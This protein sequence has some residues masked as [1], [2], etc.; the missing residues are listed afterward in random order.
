MRV[1]E[2]ETAL[3]AAQKRVED[4]ETALKTTQER[5]DAQIALLDQQQRTLQSQVQNIQERLQFCSAKGLTAQMKKSLQEKLDQFIAYLEKVG[6]TNLTTQVSVC[7]FSKDEPIQNPAFA[8]YKDVNTLYD[9]SAHN[10]YIHSDLARV[11]S[12]VLRAYTDHALTTVPDKP[13]DSSSSELIG[14][15][16]DYFSASFLDSPL[17]GEGAGSIFGMKTSYVRT[18]ATD[19]S[20]PSA[21]S[22]PFARGEV[23]G[24]VLWH[25]RGEL[26]RPVV[27]RIALQALREAGKTKSPDAAKAFAAALVQNEAMLGKATGCFNR[28]IQQRNLPH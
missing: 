17:I 26:S 21:G 1:G 12:V 20:Y 14:G 9:A 22:E 16:G 11:P 13:N 2:A 4:T 23:W 18:L 19:K 3:K 5:I 6:F 15:L 27:D 24:A 10:L 25:C 8:H 7:V 28:Q